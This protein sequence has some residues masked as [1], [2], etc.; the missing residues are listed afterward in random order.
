[1][2]GCQRASIYPRLGGY[3]WV[4][5]LELLFFARSLLK[6]EGYSDTISEEGQFSSGIIT[7]NQIL[8]KSFQGTGSVMN[9]VII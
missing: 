2:S 8:L 4:W 5:I 3:K 6:E 1:L 7:S 9:E